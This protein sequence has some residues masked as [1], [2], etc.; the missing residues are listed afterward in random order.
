[1]DPSYE[2][3]YLAR[4]VSAKL[5]AEGDSK[6]VNKAR[7]RQACIWATGRLDKAIQYLATVEEEEGATLPFVSAR[8]PQATPAAT[9]A[10]RGRSR[11]API[12][13]GLQNVVSRA[14]EQSKQLVSSAST[15]TRDSHDTGL[16]RPPP[17]RQ[18]RDWS[19]A[20]LS[21]GDN[22]P[23]KRATTEG[24]SA[25][26]V[27]VGDIALPYNIDPDKIF[28]EETKK[29][30]GSRLHVSLLVIKKGQ[31]GSP[32]LPENP[33]HDDH[34]INTM[35]RLQAFSVI[36]RELRKA[37]QLGTVPDMKNAVAE[38]V[39]RNIESEAEKINQGIKASPPNY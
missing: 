6:P 38:W 15:A 4:Y 17:L 7:F 37:A 24:A 22:P 27:Q 11:P 16:W 3:P 33:N 13:R 28:D 9:T 36:S 32:I 31:D 5:E 10:G 29:V 23:A 35:H 18:K 25:T 30:V 21:Q 2:F 12:A 26:A 1:M 39:R 14:S 20:H 19:Q 8:P 34:E